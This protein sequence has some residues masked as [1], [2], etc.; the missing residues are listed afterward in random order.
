MWIH[1]AVD[2]YSHRPYPIWLYL[3][4]YCIY[5][6]GHFCRKYW[7]NYCSHF[8]KM[9]G[10]DTLWQEN[11]E[12]P[13]IFLI[14]W[15]FFLFLIDLARLYAVEW[16]SVSLG[17]K[18]PWNIVLDSLRYCQEMAVAYSVL[19]FDQYFPG[20]NSLYEPYIQ[21]GILV[22]WTCSFL[23]VYASLIWQGISCA[24]PWMWNSPVHST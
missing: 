17:A 5:V 11:F 9:E 22:Q 7:R 20:W 14:D 23:I 12:I 8:F 1:P 18:M 21:P 10:K 13:W 6:I 4:V 16:S 3:H 15:V 2:N 24:T 19:V